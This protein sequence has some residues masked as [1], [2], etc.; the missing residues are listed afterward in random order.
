MMMVS[1]QGHF[2][3]TI[4]Q[5]FVPSEKIKDNL[6]TLKPFKSN[7]QKL[8]NPAS[9]LKKLADSRMELLLESRPASLMPRPQPGLCKNLTKTI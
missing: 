8:P 4:M 9:V 5:D 6:P 3:Y 7:R 1:A 2:G